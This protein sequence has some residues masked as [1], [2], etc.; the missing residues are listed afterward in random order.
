MVMETIKTRCGRVYRVIGGDHYVVAQQAES[1]RRW[2]VS[3]GIELLDDG[4]DR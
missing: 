4:D 3:M 2:L 1:A